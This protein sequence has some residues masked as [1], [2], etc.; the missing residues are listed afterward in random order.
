MQ[1]YKGYAKHIEASE[2]VYKWI[3]SRLIPYLKDH[4]EDQG[5]IEHIIDYLASPEAPNNIGSMM[6][7]QA[8]K[9][10]EKW[11]KTL[12]KRGANIKETEEDTEVV[13]DFNDGFKIVKLVGKNAFEREGTLMSNCVASYY[14]RSDTEVYSLRDKDNMPHCTFEAS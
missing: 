11:L 6:Y 3:D 1:D 14:G 13:L 8:K 7:D 2:K 10:A 5:E 12:M 9:N 4:P